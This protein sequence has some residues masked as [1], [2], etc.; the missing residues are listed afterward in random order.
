MKLKS[1]T[2]SRLRMAATGNSNRAIPAI[3]NPRPTPNE[4]RSRGVDGPVIALK[5]RTLGCPTDGRLMSVIPTVRQPP[6][7]TV[8]V[9]PRAAPQFHGQPMGHERELQM[10]IVRR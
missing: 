6:I 7:G 4:R 3:A 2:V 10:T 5:S 8:L 1:Q 9:L